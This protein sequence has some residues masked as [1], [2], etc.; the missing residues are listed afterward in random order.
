MKPKPY[1]QVRRGKRIGIHGHRGSRGTHPENTI[2]AFEEAALAGA[3]FVELDLQLSRDGVPI[4]Y[5]NPE[6]SGHHCRDEQGVTLTQPISIRSLDA[7]EIILF[8][9]GSIPQTHFPDQKLEPGQRVPTLERV[10]EWVSTRFPKLGI[11][12][13]IK[14]DSTELSPGPDPQT[15]SEAVFE[16]IQKYHFQE[17]VIVQSFD[18]RPLQF[19]RQRD[20]RMTISCLFGETCDFVGRIKDVGANICAPHFKLANQELIESLHSQGIEILPWTVNL[21]SDWQNLIRLNVDGIIT[22]FP[23][24]L[25]EW[26]KQN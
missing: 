15:F 10:F 17:R 25:V 24:R 23:R 21:D 20:P 4:V 5:H 19:I 1:L 11:N 26:V 2:A 13:E 22:D 16:L 18:F 14:I 7:E 3:D 8:E 6:L 12:I 9:C